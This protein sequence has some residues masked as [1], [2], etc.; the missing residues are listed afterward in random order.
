MTVSVFL[1]HNVNDKPFV[2]NLARDL[3]NHG[4]K[5]WLDEAEIKVGDS[6]IEKI[7]SGLDEVDYVTVILS[8]NSIASS[9]VQREMDVAMNQE[10]NGKRVK[11][12]PIMHQKCELPGFLLGKL[13]ADFTDTSKYQID[14][15]MVLGC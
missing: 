11:V 4:V 13:Y 10:I 7:R 9:W 3:E 15:K 5:Y 6:L 2:R 8:P 12:L 1:S 14:L